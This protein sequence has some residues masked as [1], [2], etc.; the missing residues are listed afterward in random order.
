MNSSSLHIGVTARR[1]FLKFGAASALSLACVPRELFAADSAN[2]GAK[3]VMRCAVMSDIHFNGKPDAKEVVRLRRVLRFMYEYSA[4]QPYNRFDALVV[5]GDMSNNGVREQIGLFKKTL[6]EEIHGETKTLLCMGNHEFYGGNQE[7]WREV[8]GVEPNARYEVNGFQF[9]AVSP[10]KGTMADGDYMYKR[11]WLRGELEAATKADPA[12]PIFVFQ[13]YPISPTI[14]GGRGLNDWGAE[15]LFDTLQQYPR[16][17]DFSGHS[18]YPLKDPRIVWQGNFT[19]FGTSTLSYI[20]QGAEGGRYPEY[21]EGRDNY[22]E[23]YVMEVYSDNKV[24]MTPYDVAKNEFYGFSYVVSPGDLDSYRYTDARYFRTAKPYWLAGEN[25]KVLDVSDSYA[26]IRIRQAVC[27]DVVFGYRLEIR[28]QAADGEWIVEPPKY[29]ASLYYANPAPADVA[30]ELEGLEP[31]TNYRVAV[32]A[33][34]AFNRESD[35]AVEIAFRTAADPYAADKNAA[36]PAPNFIDLRPVDGKIVNVPVNSLGARKAPK[37]I[38]TVPVVNDAELGADALLLDGA[39]SLVA[40]PCDSAEY[41]R[42]RKPTIGVKFRVDSNRASGSASIL[43]NTEHRGAAICVDYA[44]KTV[45][46]W[47]HVNGQYAVATA[48]APV[49]QWT[50]AFGV[51]DGNDLILYI[52]GA[53]AARVHV[54]GVVAHPTDPKFQVW[55][56]GGEIA[57]EGKYNEFFAGSVARACIYTWPLSPEQVKNVSENF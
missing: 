29:C 45:S 48:E 23:C 28:R 11:E 9:I 14:Y 46:Y 27:P 33:I 22:A 26:K 34:S 53:E 40:F 2:Q 52:N 55:G 18:H 25:L 54:E 6:D 5:V 56:V 10:E 20:C 35:D 4:Q 51:Y 3:C 49:G 43:S 36:A 57:P 13:H 1:D 41:S 21:P 44:A 47:A 19:A 12:K 24:L 50:V 30:A 31:L 15:D 7:L 42:L 39:G 8:F 37:I 38:G 17:I 16:V 32:T